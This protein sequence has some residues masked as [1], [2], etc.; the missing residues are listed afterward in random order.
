[1]FYSLTW[2]KI[3]IALTVITVKVMGAREMV[4]KKAKTQKMDELYHMVDCYVHL[5]CHILQQYLSE[6]WK[7]LCTKLKNWVIDFFTLYSKLT[8]FSL[9]SCQ[10]W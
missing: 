9:T 6:H 8:L 7:P 2:V 10:I 1:M 4:Q 5:F 3:T